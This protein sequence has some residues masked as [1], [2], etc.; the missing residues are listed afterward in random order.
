MNLFI[1][2]RVFY[3]LDGT[4]RCCERK[5]KHKLSWRARNFLKLLG[6]EIE[7]DNTVAFPP[8]TI[9]HVCECSIADEE[10]SEV[11]VFS[12]L[13]KYIKGKDTIQIEIFSSLAMVNAVN[14]NSSVIGVF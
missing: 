14:N 12:I 10:K 7:Q 4:K 8:Q 3:G 5:F 11:Q 13:V 6:C 9:V 2:W 1:G